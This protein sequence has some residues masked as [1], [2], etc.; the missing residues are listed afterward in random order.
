[1]LHR[2][3]LGALLAPVLLM[4]GC[5][6]TRDLVKSDKVDY[7]TEGQVKTET[8]TLEIPPDLTKPGLNR[9]YEIPG[10]GSTKRN[11]QA[12][13]Q[14]VKPAAREAPSGVLPP[15][16]GIRMERGGSQRW[17]VVTGKPD[18]YWQAIKEFWQESGFL[19]SIDSPE[20]GVMETDWAENR[21][22]IRKDFL[23]RFMGS[24]LD[25]VYSTPER[26]KF[27]TRLEV[28]ANGET[29]I[30]VSHRGMVEIYKN[31]AREQT[32]WQQRPADP[33]LEA[34][35]L[36]R[37]MLRLG[38]DEKQV[39]IVAK[40]GA[41]PAPEKAV[42]IKEGG[43]SVVVL[44]DTFD[45]AWRRV[46]LALDRVGFTVEDR[47]RSKGMFFVRYADPDASGKKK[48]EGFLSSMTNWFNTDK[49]A[50]AEQYQIKVSDAD[51]KSKV[52]V[53]SKTGV[54]ENSQTSQRILSLLQEQLK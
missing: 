42:I 30:Y 25:G 19:L 8:S 2:I 26:D 40:A 13:D 47:D 24:M 35:F 28:N 1:M 34:D 20:T 49:S 44:D 46:G 50:P 33:E 37:M 54:P 27:R 9:R 22:Q 7:K 29:E 53:L 6:W 52:T 23:G 16:A 43:Y 21:S 45:R 31:E 41:V 14:Q 38:S 5:T 11:V 51:P 48:S 39:A 32:T 12:S 4:T 18:Q 36:R 17:L 10:D 3:F 15:V